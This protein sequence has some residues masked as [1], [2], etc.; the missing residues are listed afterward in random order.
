MSKEIGTSV[1]LSCLAS[2]TPTP[3]MKWLK[4]AVDIENLTNNCCNNK[5][6]KFIDDG[7]KL[8]ISS[9][10]TSDSGMYQCMASNSAG[11]DSS[12]TWLHAKSKLFI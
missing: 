9:L 12:Y 4:N 5:R 2:G 6:F 8:E 10:E 7:Y 3:E 1:L 11:Q